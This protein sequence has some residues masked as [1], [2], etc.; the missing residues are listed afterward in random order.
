[1]LQFFQ[2]QVNVYNI[3]LIKCYYTDG[4]EKTFSLYEAIVSNIYHLWIIKENG[5]WQILEFCFA[6]CGNPWRKRKLRNQM[7]KDCD[8]KSPQVQ[9]YTASVI[10]RSV[11]FCTCSKSFSCISFFFFF[12]CH[13]SYTNRQISFAVSSHSVFLMSKQRWAWVLLSV[14][15]FWLMYHIYLS[16]F[17]MANERRYE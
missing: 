15:L 2:Y 9:S 8:I 4:T 6:F 16:I 3:S 17:V 13:Y 1:M 11:T 5:L 7:I 12:F 14:Y 10:H